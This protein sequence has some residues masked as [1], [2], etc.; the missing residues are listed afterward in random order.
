MA[1]KKTESKTEIKGI[2]REYIIPIREKTRVVPRYKKT[3]KAVKT[4]KEFLVKHMKVYDRDLDKVKIDMYL[5]EYLWFR[6][7]RK[8]PYKVK[9]RAVKE[10]ELIRVYLAEEHKRVEAKRMRLDKREKKA[11]DAGAKVPKKEG[12]SVESTSVKA[13]EK[14][15]ES[16]EEEKE[17][18]AAVEEAGEKKA[19]EEH[20]KSKHDTK[21]ITPEMEKSKSKIYN[22]SSRGK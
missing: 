3:P 8:P 16:K 22:K 6:G 4:I 14:T 9:V 20:K 7:I 13:E 2:E 19:K 11:Q 1:K 21:I 12:K 18:D 10:G 15:E 17:K 5:N